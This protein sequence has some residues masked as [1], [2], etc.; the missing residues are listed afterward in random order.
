MNKCFSL[1][2]SLLTALALSASAQTNPY[3]EL[4]AYDFGRKSDALAA[5]QQEIREAKPAAYPAIEAKLLAAIAQPD[6]TY[7]CKKFVCEQLRIIGSEACVAPLLKQLG[8]EK[9]A[10]VARLALENLPCKAVCDGL[11]AALKTSSGKVQIGIINTLAARHN[12]EL[13]G[14][15]K[16]YLGSGNADLVRASL[17][18]LARVGGAGAVET[19]KSAQVPAEFEP[20]RERALMDAAFNLAKSGDKGAAVAVFDEEFRKGKSQPAVIAALNGLVDF[21]GARGLIAVCGALKDSHLQVALAAAKAA[22]RMENKAIAKELC[23]ALPGLPPAVQVA[24]LR[25]L[26]ERCEKS[27]LPAVKTALGSQDEAVKVEAALALEKV[28]NSSV[29]GDLIALATGEGDVAAAAQQTLGRINAKGVN[30]AMT[31]ML[32]DADAKKVRVAALTLKARADHA[33]VPRLLTMAGSEKS[34]LRGVA[35]EALDGFA[36]TEEMPALL[37]LLEKADNKDKVASVLWKATQ[38][39]GTEDA[40]FAKLWT[41]ASG[42]SEPARAALISL[43]STG[44]GAESL[45]IVTDTLTSGSAALKDPAARTLFNWKTDAAVAP[46]ANLIKTTS[47]AKHKILGARAVVRIL[48]DRKCGWNAKKKTETLEQLLPLLDRPE[49]KKMIEGAIE[50]IKHP[51]K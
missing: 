21:G 42:C 14:V 19:L 51:K 30:E 29:V 28:G 32:D 33:V 48:T 8:E 17:Q 12:P 7:A 46:L 44:A 37:A 41:S 4:P 47:D 26:A 45:K 13:V 25:T 36:G 50:T 39:V 2:F 27:A 9:S 6:A 49:D 1:T 5:I 22:Q 23:S 40:R 16:G 20:L 18:A 35:L 43:G 31:R 24:V 38:A 3:A 15:V 10:D 11:L 34:D